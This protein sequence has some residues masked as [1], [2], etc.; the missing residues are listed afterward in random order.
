MKP[1]GVLPA[2]SGVN[3]NGPLMGSTTL[4]VKQDLANWIKVPYNLNQLLPT[5]K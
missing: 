4:V 2:N 1:R 3:R 5:L